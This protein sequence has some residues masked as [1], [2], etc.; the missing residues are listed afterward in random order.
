MRDDHGKREIPDSVGARIRYLRKQLNLSLKDLERM[1]GVSPSYINRLEKNHRKAPSV[2]IIY[3]LAPALG[4]AP[5][6]LMEMTEEEQREK[7]VIELVLTHHYTICNGIQATQP[8]KD[9]LAELLQTVMSSDLDGK[10]K[11]RDSIVIIEK[12]REFLRLIRE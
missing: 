12:V 3:K 5:Q 2:P 10:N 8:M 4:V 6:E 1:T 7:D 9:S 11:V